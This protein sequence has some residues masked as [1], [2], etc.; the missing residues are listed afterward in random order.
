MV[1]CTHMGHDLKEV[2]SI[3]M[4]T[5]SGNSAA[6]TNPEFLSIFPEFSHRYGHVLTLTPIVFSHTPQEEGSFTFHQ[7]VQGQIGIMILEDHGGR[8]SHTA[9]VGCLGK[10]E[11][12]E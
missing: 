1:H 6:C 10:P 3:K 5:I 7:N 12:L 9:S 2:A 8:M 4:Q 11:R